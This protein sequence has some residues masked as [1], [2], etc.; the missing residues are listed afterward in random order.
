M[1][2]ER[3][4]AFDLL[5]ELADFTLEHGLPKTSMRIE[6]ALDAFL[7]ETGRTQEARSAPRPAK[8]RPR[9]PGVRPP[10]T[11]ARGA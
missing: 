5:L 10:W 7:Q 2:D 4:L 11:A 3:D 9:R 6:A 1:T 8:P